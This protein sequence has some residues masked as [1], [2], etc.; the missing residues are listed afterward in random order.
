M[1]FRGTHPA[2]LLLLLAP[3]LQAAAQIRCI[4]AGQVFDGRAFLGPKVILIR[5]GL[6]AD[7]LDTAGALPAGAETIDAS[8][9]TLLP[10]FIDS[11]I[12]CMAPPMPQTAEV[13]KR[14]WGRLAAEGFSLMPE[15]RFHLLASG[16]T[17]VADMG[18]PLDG[19]LNLREELREGRIAGPDLFFP[20]PLFTAPGG[21]P[22][23]TFYRGRH[24]LIDKGCVQSADTEEARE[25]VRSLARAGVDYIKLVSDRQ[26]YI[27]DP[28]PRLDPDVAGAIID[29]SHALGLKVFG[30]AGSE[31]E[32]M[33]LVRRGIDGI[34]HCFISHSDSL[35]LEMAKRNVILTPTLVA[36]RHYAPAVA[37]RMLEAVR[38]AHRLNVRIAAGT[39]FPT[40]Y[41]ER[42]GEDLFE[43]LRLLE[44]AGMSRSALLAAATGTGA[45]KIGKEGEFGFVAKGRAADLLIY[46]GSLEEGPLDAAKISG[47]MLRGNL[48]V[49]DHAP[50]SSSAAGFERRSLLLFPYGFWD[51]LYGFLLGVSVTEFDFL[52]TGIAL[53]GDVLYSF[54]AMGAVNLAASFPSPVA[55]TALQ[56]SVHA[57]NLNRMFYGTGNAAPKEG[58]IEFAMR[59]FREQIDA[60]TSLSERWKLFPMIAAEQ[61]RLF[62]YEGKR[63]AGV[64]GVEGG[65][66]IL[67]GCRLAWDTRDHQNNPWEGVLAS[68]GAE[69]SLSLGAMSHDFGSIQ[70]DFR[71]YF[72]PAQKHV[73]AGRILFRSAA[74]NVP[75]FHLPAY[76]GVNLGRGYPYV[77][78]LDKNG[79]ASQAEYRFP[80][81]RFISGVGFLEF[82]QVQ[83]DIRRFSLGAFHPCAGFGIRFS[84]GSNENSI[85]GLDFGFSSEGVA[86]LFRRG[87]AF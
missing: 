64:A 59:N 65:D 75:F 84:F 5:E 77:R 58:G 83:S 44:S 60:A 13:A 87:H 23:G 53:E 38:R 22:A 43:E 28:V 85:L 49:A 12:H 46:N 18:A 69:R 27:G 25:S 41:G 80:L 4:R 66:E 26:A 74:G 51:T 40:S 11:H 31:E 45:G 79:L 9:G 19:Y 63:P 50:T 17:A 71:G 73:V 16:I 61:Y 54:R 8:G 21:H 72:S 36:F 39:D 62:S 15:N 29:A 34:E 33:A 78:F 2:I 14:G 52:R 32:A 56:A 3:L 70:C 20:G 68:V 55:N 47:V 10:G 48:V 1:R 7:I 37:P 35:F 57:D 42:C 81:W 30:H 6:I 82:G 24:D 76:G 86:I 67:L